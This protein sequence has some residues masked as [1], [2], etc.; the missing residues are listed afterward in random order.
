MPEAIPS[1]EQSLSVLRGA[2]LWPDIGEEPGALGRLS[3][4]C[5]AGCVC[6]GCPGDA[7]GPRGRA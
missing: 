5:D 3:R 1:K 7:R 6:Q 4:A 2:G